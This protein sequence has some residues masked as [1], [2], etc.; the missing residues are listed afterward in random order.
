MQSALNFWSCASRGI[1]AICP[2]SVATGVPA[3]RRC[4]GQSPGVYGAGGELGAGNGRSAVL[5]C[6]KLGGREP[7]YRIIDG[8]DTAL[9]MDKFCHKQLKIHYLPLPQLIATLHLYNKED[10][11]NKFSL[12]ERRRYCP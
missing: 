3:K 10:E 11:G 5:A 8:Y 1:E 2:L 6:G 7:R 9:L 12:S 4:W